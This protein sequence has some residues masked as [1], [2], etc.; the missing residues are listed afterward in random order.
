MADAS[1][2][3]NS[4]KTL[5]AVSSADG[6]T[7]LKVYG[8]PTTH[9]LLVSSALSVS[10]Q[11]TS[12]VTVTSSDSGKVFTN[13]GA[14]GKI[15]FNLPTAVANYNYTFVVED[16]DGIDVVASAGDTIQF[17]S[18]VT[19]AAGTIT[20][21]TIGSSITLV[22]INATEWVATSLVGTWA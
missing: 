7:P 2:D 1:T 8:N 13:E 9:R 22:A 4:A 12:P 15:V 6:S 11:S 21:T 14:T 18:T 20:S 10:A 16:A 19:A 3:S 17:A 5:L